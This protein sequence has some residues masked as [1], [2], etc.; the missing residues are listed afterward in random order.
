LI[1]VDPDSQQIYT[2]NINTNEIRIESDVDIDYRKKA[3]AAIKNI[4]SMLNLK[5]GQWLMAT[6]EIDHYR[7]R[8]I[9]S[10]LLHKQSSS[11]P[12]YLC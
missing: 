1:C 10:Y 2:L 5:N 12:T 3:E 7:R 11:Y 8:K 6:K 4:D 9:P